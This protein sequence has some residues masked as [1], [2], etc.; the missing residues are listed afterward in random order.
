MLPCWAAPQWRHLTAAPGRA[1]TLCGL[2]SLPWPARCS[3]PPTRTGRPA[4]WRQPCPP[5]NRM[6]PPAM[7]TAP[8]RQQRRAAQSACLLRVLM[9]HV[10]LTQWCA[11]E[12]RTGGWQAAPH[13][14][15][16]CR[17]C[18]ARHVLGHI[19]ACVFAGEARR[20][21]AGSTLCRPVLPANKTQPTVARL[22][23]LEDGDEEPGAQGVGILGSSRGPHA[24]E[25]AKADRHAHD[26]DHLSSRGLGSETVESM[27]SSTA[28]E[29]TEASQPCIATHSH[30]THAIAAKVG[31]QN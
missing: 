29:R 4:A 8:C 5:Y 9:R 26:G 20:F 7:Q 27:A 10:K 22:P 23:H 3:H 31:A 19:T 28:A 30:A 13:W 24:T 1:R 16:R 11:P 6:S 14:P 2:S 25:N 21:R 12:G 18:P 17:L 15:L